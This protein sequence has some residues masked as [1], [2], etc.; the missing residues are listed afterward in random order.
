M[1]LRALRTK[2]LS[3]ILSV[4]KELANTTFF[5]DP[6][7]C[8][9]QTNISQCLGLKSASFGTDTHGS[10]P[11]M[12]LQSKSPVSSCF[13]DRRTSALLEGTSSTSIF[14][15]QSVIAQPAVD[16]K[17]GYIKSSDEGLDVL[18]VYQQPTGLKRLYYNPIRTQI[19]MLG[20]VRLMGPAVSSVTARRNRKSA[21]NAVDDGT[22]IEF[23]VLTSHSDVNGDSLDKMIRSDETNVTTP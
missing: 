20:F 8:F 15:P 7:I 2:T 22:Y 13:F 14:L 18:K 12:Y 6:R 19:A 5:V 17:K 11:L 10:L 21:A 1:T 4:D 9:A 23:L 16:E 3:D